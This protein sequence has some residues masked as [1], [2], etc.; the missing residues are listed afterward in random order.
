LNS[1]ASLTLLGRCSTS[2]A[3]LPFIVIWSSILHLWLPKLPVL[4]IQWPEKSD[5]Q[6]MNFQSHSFW[7]TIGTWFHKGLKKKWGQRNSILSP[8]TTWSHSLFSSCKISF[9]HKVKLSTLD[10][11]MI[12]FLPSHPHL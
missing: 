7:K 8:K 10:F 12:E 4:V 11:D 5:S 3:V 1:R 6:W 2:W 9:V